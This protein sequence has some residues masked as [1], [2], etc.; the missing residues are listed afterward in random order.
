MCEHMNKHCGWIY[1]WTNSS[2]LDDGW[3]MPGAIVSGA[4][5][6]AESKKAFMKEC[7][8]VVVESP[9]NIGKTVATILK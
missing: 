3:D 5:E 8:L 9:A 2:S 1:C 4:D 7:G 6:S